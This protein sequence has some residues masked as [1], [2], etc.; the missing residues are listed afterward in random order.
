MNRPAERNSQDEFVMFN[1]LVRDAANDRCTSYYYAVDVRAN[2]Y[3]F[4]ERI[5]NSIILFLMFSKKKVYI[6]L[7]KKFLSFHKEIICF[8]LFYYCKMDHT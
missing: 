4:S 3:S 8:I 7:S 6:R 2:S 1:S 5:K